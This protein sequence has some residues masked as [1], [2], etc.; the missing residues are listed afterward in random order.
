MGLVPL[1]KRPREPP[2]P[3]PPCGHRRRCRPRTG[4]RLSPDTRPASTQILDVLPPECE[5]EM[6]AAGPGEDADSSQE[7][8]SRQ[9]ALREGLFLASDSPPMEGHI[10]V[11]I[12]SGR[13]EKH[14][15]NACCSRL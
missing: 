4:M 1:W 5:E 9:D 11:L 10:C 14:F 2:C 13:K 6:P 7:T 12:T 8:Y 15:L 3:F